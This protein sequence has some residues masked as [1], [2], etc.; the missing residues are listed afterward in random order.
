MFQTKDNMG[1]SN[2]SI[3]TA[4]LL[5]IGLIVVLLSLIS[6]LTSYHIAKKSLLK[7]ADEMLMNKS[8]DSANLVDSRIQ[9][10]ISSIEPLGDFDTL[11]DPNIQWYEKQAVLKRE[12][13]RLGLTSIGITDSS[14]KLS[15]D[16]G[17]I[18]NVS[19]YSYYQA[20]KRGESYFSEPFFND[21]SNHMEVAI[22]T[23][24]KYNNTVTGVVIAFKSADEF[25]ALANDIKIG[26]AGYAYLLNDLADVVSHPTMVAGLETDSTSGATAD[27][28]SSTTVDATS[29]ATGNSYKVS[30][31]SLSVVADKSSLSEIQRMNEN[32]LN[33][34]ADA[35]KYKENGNYIHI[36]HAPIKSKGWTLI[37]TVTE[38]D[39]LS[40][41]GTMR[42]SLL[43]IGII[44]LAI[45][46][47]LSY[48]VNSRITKRII[49]I[50]NKT[51]HLSNL[52]LTFTLDDKLI[53]REDELGTMAK[54][55]QSVLETIKHF[56]HETQ[57]SSGS[58][59][60]SSQELVAI[61]EES[62]ATA[63]SI[64]EASYEIMN[65][66]RSQ[67]EEVQKI[68]TEMDHVNTQFAQALAESKEVENLSKKAANSTEEGKKVVDEVIVQMDNIKEGTNRVK[69]SLDNIKISSIKMDEILVVIESIAEQT[70]LLALNAAIEAARAGEAG[71][72]F[73]VVAEE[74]RKLA[75]QTMNSTDEINEIIKNNHKLILTANESME[76][77]NT[78]V[79]RGI[80][81][82]N[83]TKETFDHIAEIIGDMNMG[84]EKSI[85]AID[86]VANNIE[87]ATYSIGETEN[88]SREV[89]QQ[90]QTVSSATEDQMSSM[91]Q[92]TASADSLSSLA[93][94]LQDIFKNIKL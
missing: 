69:D 83:I 82:V 8:I 33:R 25:Y 40:E 36:G 24:L 20:G 5:T 72:G 1:K 70:N 75:D 11:A 79:N 23:P 42:N 16:D 17:N 89:T 66:S 88:L 28:Y 4:L 39:I 81:K 21:L 14:G 7:Q 78:E 47:T 63:T 15:L 35:G 58:V 44:S 48:M 59:A 13:S 64:A 10:Y 73:S 54:A 68:S 26:E 94:D 76:V 61:T 12:K 2:K 29:S 6:G 62:T 18:V 34:V 52:D 31:E 65:K 53:N 71:R 77:N 43:L 19:D 91:E 80:E 30:L 74:I 3:A 49:D 86:A 37:V 87:I 56:A 85:D 38:K 41:L 55:I 93:E 9:M 22:A 51:K 27:A 84:M 67:L 46:L 50:S 45:A 90:I 60:A 32:I 57:N 92:I